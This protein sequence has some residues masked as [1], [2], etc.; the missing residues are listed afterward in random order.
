M[1]LD[2]AFERFVL[3]QRSG[4]TIL[5]IFIKNFSMPYSPL[6]YFP[7]DMVALAALPFVRSFSES[8]PPQSLL[9]HLAKCEGAG[10]SSP[11]SADERAK[12]FVHELIFRYYL[13]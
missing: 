10:E 8:A 6:S 12:R 1:W 7:F 13:F 2:S 3:L 9:K 4:D 11:C 5:A